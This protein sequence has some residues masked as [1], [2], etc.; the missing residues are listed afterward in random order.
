[1]VAPLNKLQHTEQE[2]ETPPVTAI[3]ND[4]FKQLNNLNFDPENPDHISVLV[5]GDYKRLSP[6]R[7]ERI[8]KETQELPE[9]QESRC[10]ESDF[11]DKD[12][13]VRHWKAVMVNLY[14]EYGGNWRRV[15]KDSRSVSRRTLSSY[16][17][18]EIFRARL[19][20][21]DPV[22]AL[23]ARGVVVEIYSEGVDEKTRLAAALR[24]L[25]YHDAVQWDKGVRK[26][27]V[28]NKGSLQNTL[29]S[30]AISDDEYIDVFIRDRLN[31][32]PEPV[33]KSLAESMK[34]ELPEAEKV[35]DVTPEERVDPVIRT[36]DVTKL[37][38]PFGDEET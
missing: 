19:A 31:R 37:K 15:L 32:L 16:F 28:A 38:D 29:L 1:M 35:I 7:V 18:D 21:L 26:Q 34:K 27:I 8:T 13:G 25:E 14:F 20:A 24:F 11:A 30:K 5:N 12:A 4:L 9:K 10:T 17:G 3:N 22:L 23:E 6:E 33:R 36:A 2:D